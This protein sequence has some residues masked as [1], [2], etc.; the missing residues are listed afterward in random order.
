M[1]EYNIQSKDGY[2][3]FNLSGRA[4]IVAAEKLEQEFNRCIKNGKKDFILDFSNITYFS[5]TGVRVI[6]ALKNAVDKMNGKLKI[7]KINSI[8]KKILR[9]L[10][11]IN[12]YDI[13]DTY[14]QA[15]K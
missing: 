10:D 14:E 1:F 4:D 5:S 6:I 11:L 3:V 2:E 15:V 13:Y 12:Y 7:V 9:A 8:V